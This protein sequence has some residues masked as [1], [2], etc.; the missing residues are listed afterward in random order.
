[1]DERNLNTGPLDEGKPPIPIPPVEEGWKQMAARLDAVMPVGTATG[2][3]ASAAGGAAVKSGSIAL[4]KL[5]VGL[6]VIVT[7]GVISVVYFTQRANDKDN[8][9]QINTSAGWQTDKAI[10]ATKQNDSL[11][12]IGGKDNKTNENSDAQLKGADGSMQA[13][14]AAGSQDSKHTQTPD[15]ASQVTDQEEHSSGNQN[16]K[17]HHTQG[18]NGSVNG[19]T[20]AERYTGN[21]KGKTLQATDVTVNS[22]GKSAVAQ[23]GS[24]HDLQDA[25]GIRKETAPGK[26]GISQPEGMAATNHRATF[27]KQGDKSTGNDLGH[28]DAKKN[29][30][31][32]KTSKN[33]KA[34]GNKVSGNSL[35]GNHKSTG[36]ATMK[37]NHLSPKMQGVNNAKEESA[38]KNSDDGHPQQTTSDAT[39]SSAQHNNPVQ[40]NEKGVSKDI[41]ET[42]P[43]ADGQSVI[44]GNTTSTSQGNIVA[45]TYAVNEGYQRTA[46]TRIRINNQFEN[47]ILKAPAE[48]I[49]HL[50]SFRPPRKGNGMSWELL[51]QWSL[52]MPIN[53]NTWL[54]G[55]TANPQAYTLLI[56]GL[57]LQYD[58]PNAAISLD[59]NGFA[60]QAYK[61]VPYKSGP[62]PSAV[63]TTN[64]YTLQKSFGYSA[65]IAYQHRVYKNW[66]G[67]AG[68]QAFYAREGTISLSRQ[69]DTILLAPKNVTYSDKSDIWKRIGRVHWSITAE[70]Y[71]DHN[72]WQ[73]GGR[74]QIPVL[75][76]T[77]TITGMIK[78]QIQAEILLRIKL[79]K[80]K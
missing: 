11:A 39:S 67:A 55:P 31:G 43:I 10:D 2:A 52:P 77:D 21:Q 42:Y 47:K 7:L 23:N 54:K 68:I 48:A 76:K 64:S 38:N 36:A 27:T 66:Y 24:G 33:T 44:T 56:P 50:F 37:D 17:E 79:Y 59:L 35:G 51:V 28:N 70:G 78:P 46:L 4:G 8:K 74:V 9:K 73:L 12:I 20:P 34:H 19:T 25:D 71:Y 57:R 61:D 15:N 14:N 58:M 22:G 18:T 65:G 72:R 32:V 3:A 75:H 16:D 5:L 62:D 30:E 69:S 80:K 41:R 40:T 1:M 49:N 53:G 45:G 63:R 60:S 13:G 6:A 26:K 29:N